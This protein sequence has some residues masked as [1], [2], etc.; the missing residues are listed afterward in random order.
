MKPRDEVTSARIIPAMEPDEE[1]T[2]CLAEPTRCLAPTCSVLAWTLEVDQPIAG[3]SVRPSEEMLPAIERKQLFG[4]DAAVRRPR[5]GPTPIGRSLRE[6]GL[7]G[8]IL[9][10]TQELRKAFVIKESRV[11]AG[12]PVHGSPA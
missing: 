9:E 5:T 7:D 4:L 2:R 1:P 3:D 6:P 12:L 11:I 8:V 10:V